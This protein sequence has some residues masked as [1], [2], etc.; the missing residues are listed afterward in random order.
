M[1]TTV[2]IDDDLLARARERFPPGTPKTVILEEGLRL[3]VAT[4]SGPPAPPRL[5]DPRL[6]RLVAAGKLT[7]A[8]A[9]APPAPPGDGLP[10]TR[11]LA[12]LAADR[13]DR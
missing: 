2:N 12:D 9:Q 3:L 8:T 6:D 10:L 13:A 4:A 11:L 5:A 1:R 7:P